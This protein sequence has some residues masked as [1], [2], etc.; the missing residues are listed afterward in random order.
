[1]Q[2]RIDPC[3]RAY[4][5]LTFIVP[6]VRRAVSEHENQADLKPDVRENVPVTT[7]PKTTHDNTEKWCDLVCQADLV[8]AVVRNCH[9]A[10]EK[11]DSQ[12]GL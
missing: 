11:G 6:V 7:E 2:N 10:R 9:K 3:S 4:A 1:M 5:K 12:Y 8:A